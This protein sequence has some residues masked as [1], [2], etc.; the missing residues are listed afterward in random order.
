AF[1]YLR[2]RRVTLWPG[3][4]K[5]PRTHAT[6]AFARAL[7]ALEKRGYSRGVAET[8][9]ELAVRV[10]QGGDPAAQPFSQLV[11]LYYASRFG[12]KQIPSSEL[13]QL[14]QQVTSPA[15]SSHPESR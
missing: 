9:R 8:G 15:V 3:M 1:W 6:T 13:D 4:T 5:V 2:R 14:A 12:E 10:E 7:R 11:E